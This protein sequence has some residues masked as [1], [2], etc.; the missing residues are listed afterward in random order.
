MAVNCEESI[1]AIKRARHFR[2]QQK[3]AIHCQSQLIRPSGN[4]HWQI[5]SHFVEEW[6]DL[7]QTEK[8]NATAKIQSLKRTETQHP[9]IQSSF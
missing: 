8:Q 6:T 9:H 5:F 7:P 2:L 4:R 3:S 1:H